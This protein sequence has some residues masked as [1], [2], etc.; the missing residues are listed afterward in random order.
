MGSVRRALEGTELMSQE[1]R[2]K[3][4]PSKY[5]KSSGAPCFKSGTGDSR[6]H[7]IFDG[8][9]ASGRHLLPDVG[10]LLLDV[11]HQE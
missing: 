1:R 11:E 4:T 8:S 10:F 5:V 7:D 2:P 3:T 6:H 9:L